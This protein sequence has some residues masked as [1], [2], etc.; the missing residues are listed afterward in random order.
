MYSACAREG[1]SCDHIPYP[2]NSAQIELFD[3]KRGGIFSMLDDECNTPN[4]S[5]AKFV[6]KMHDAFANKMLM[7]GKHAKE[8]Y[9]PPKYGAAA[10]GAD[11]G[12]EFAPL[13][14]T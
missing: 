12:K 14:L 13:Q 11:L 10:V 2:D 1:I 5:D 9:S 3:S 8:F 4:G 6:S 7:N